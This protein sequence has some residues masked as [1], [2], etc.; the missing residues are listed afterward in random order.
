MPPTSKL[1]KATTLP[2]SSQPL[3][4]SKRRTGLADNSVGLKNRKIDKSTDVAS[5]KSTEEDAAD[6]DV[7]MLQRR[8]KNI[9]EN[10]AMVRDI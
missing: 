7:Q 6:T 9:Q 1:N 2:V 10:K 4:R 3:G 8:A 5:V